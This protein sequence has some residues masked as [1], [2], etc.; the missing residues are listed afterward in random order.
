MLMYTFS[1][2]ISAVRERMEE[3]QLEERTAALFQWMEARKMRS[4]AM[5]GIRAVWAWYNAAEQR[6]EREKRSTRV[7]RTQSRKEAHM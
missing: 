6:E 1:G 2:P 7:K 4:A 5:D 3:V